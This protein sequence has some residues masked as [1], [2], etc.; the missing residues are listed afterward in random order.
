VG[1]L[2]R[3]GDHFQYALWIDPDYVKARYNLAV[4]FTQEGKIDDAIA[5]YRLVVQKKR[6]IP[7]EVYNNFGVI[8]LRHGDTV[9]AIEQFRQLLELQPNNIVARRNLEAALSKKNLPQ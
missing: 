5:Q 4:A 7:P 8:L 1:N 3:A 2:A 9:E 6:D